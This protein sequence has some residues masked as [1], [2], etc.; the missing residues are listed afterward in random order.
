MLKKR[1]LSINAEDS[2][3][4][5]KERRIASVSP[6]VESIVSD[7]D[8]LKIKMERAPGDRERRIQN[9]GASGSTPV[10]FDDMK[11]VE[12]QGN[13]SNRDL[14]IRSPF[15]SFIPETRDPSTR[16]SSTKSQTSA[17]QTPAFNFS[18][19]IFDKKFDQEEIYISNE[20]KLVTG[21]ETRNTTNKK[22]QAVRG[23]HR[24]VKSIKEWEKQTDLKK[25]VVLKIELNK[26]S[27]V[28]QF[29]DLSDN[30]EI[31][32]DNSDFARLAFILVEVYGLSVE[33][34][35]KMVQKNGSI[36]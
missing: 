17:L 9:I 15:V 22:A 14:R 3:R 7:V 26:T 19:D 36:I 34:D 2:D 6:L 18:F 35:G 25:P 20:E 32:W 28:R 33:S 4:P 27:L 24:E 10:L 30:F 12:L 13:P 8:E 31:I 21:R 11:H 5:G 1:D 16:I 29:K 23:I